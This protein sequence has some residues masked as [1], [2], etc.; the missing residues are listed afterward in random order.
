MVTAI[1]YTQTEGGVN[2]K[3]KVDLVPI[4]TNLLTF[5]KRS[6]NYKILHLKVIALEFCSMPMLVIPGLQVC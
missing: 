3:G 4:V 1:C 6:N 5:F 2:P